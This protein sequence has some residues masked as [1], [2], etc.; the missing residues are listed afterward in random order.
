MIVGFCFAPYVNNIRIFELRFVSF[1]TYLS[2]VV[3]FN[4]CFLF[5]VGLS[6]LSQHSQQVLLGVE[7]SSVSWLGQLT[8]GVEAKRQNKLQHPTRPVANVVITTKGL[9]ERKTQLLNGTTVEKYVIKILTEIFPSV[10]ET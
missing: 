1:I 6:L 3:S 10:H 8:V 4:S 9:E 5:P 7:V 2:I